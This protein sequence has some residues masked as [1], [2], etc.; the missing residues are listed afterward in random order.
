MQTNRV[1]LLSLI[2][3]PTVAYRI[4]AQAAVQA[5][6]TKE[7]ETSSCRIT[8]PDGMLLSYSVKKSDCMKSCGPSIGVEGRDANQWTYERK[9]ADA[10]TVGFGDG[11]CSCS[12]TGKTL[13]VFKPLNSEQEEKCKA[14]TSLEIHDE[15]LESYKR[16]RGTRYQ[17]F[18]GIRVPKYDVPFMSSAFTVHRQCQESC[19]ASR[20]DICDLEMP[21]PLDGMEPGDLKDLGDAIH[22]CQ[23][24]DTCD[25]AVKKL[26]GILPQEDIQNALWTA[27]H[28]P[29]PTPVPTP[30]PTPDPPMAVD[31]LG[32]EDVEDLD[33]DDMI[34]SSRGDD[35]DIRNAIRGGRL[36]SPTAITNDWCALLTVGARGCDQSGT[37]ACKCHFIGAKD[38]GCSDIFN[39]GPKQV[40]TVYKNTKV[41]LFMNSGCSCT[42]TDTTKTPVE[43]EC[44]LKVGQIKRTAETPSKMA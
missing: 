40:K 33:E 26:V 21:G 42:H 36:L 22:K 2:A 30:E 17:I 18:G 7:E 12:A 19:Q 15:C 37:N 34:I 6:K 5:G 8:G 13:A 38:V 35:G 4:N 28:T 9:F 3:A 29:E 24:E 11:K 43:S 1:V 31:R 32:D 23:T 16:A 41:A 44:T 39:L 10:F 14:G 25:G 27:G 20:G